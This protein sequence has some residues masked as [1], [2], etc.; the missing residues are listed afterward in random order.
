MAVVT[1]TR[2]LRRMAAWSA[3][4][5]LLFAQVCLAA[6]ACPLVLPVEASA[7]AMPAGCDGEAPPQPD[8]LCEAH[9]QGTSASV[10]AAQPPAVAILDTAP[11][12]VVASDVVAATSRRAP[13]D[14]VVATA[15]APPATIRFCR[16]LI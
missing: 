1:L 7:T 12:I 15:A 5:A 8:A 3:L 2:S 16:F 10:S 13:T 9:C 4:L 11:L 6:Y 14:D